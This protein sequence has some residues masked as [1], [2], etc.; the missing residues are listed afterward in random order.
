MKSIC[1][2]EHERST[3]ISIVRSILG[4]LGAETVLIRVKPNS[5][6]P[7]ELSWPNITLDRMS[8]PKYLRELERGNIG[9]LLGKASAHLVTID[10]DRDEDVEPFLNANPRLRD[11]TR[12][13][14][15]RGCNLWLRMGGDYPGYK[16]FSNGEWR[17]DGKHYTVIYGRAEGVAYRFI[18]E[19]P[20]ILIRFEEIVFPADWFPAESFTRPSPFLTTSAAPLLCSSATLSLCKVGDAVK[21][22]MPN[23]ASKNNRALFTL[24][25]AVKR[26]EAQGVITSQM[27]RIM[28]FDQWYQEAASRGILRAGQTRDDYLLE[29]LNAYGRAKH[30]LGEAVVDIAW[31]AAQTEPFPPES[32]IF[33]TDA[34]KRFVGLCFQMHLRADGRSWFVS[35]RT[36]G[37]LLGVSHTKAAT[38]L[39]GLVAAGIIS[40]AEAHTKNRATRYKFNP[41][42][43][44]QT[45]L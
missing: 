11:T 39:G 30:P 20:P 22:A 26:L 7:T 18:K 25:R 15:L 45:K 2:S 33:E 35:T 38:W 1:A 41:Q 32:A 43:D 9:V 44:T 3:G 34:A 17:S 27:Q 37:R 8:D 14:R 40:V 10:L 4:V 24:A 28:V 5:K 21:M 12:T 23:E 6:E 29:F 19:V 36:A 31:A 42:P 13:K 16:S